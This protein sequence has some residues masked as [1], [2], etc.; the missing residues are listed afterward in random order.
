VGAE[1]GAG[2]V[3]EAA[4]AARGFRGKRLMVARDMVWSESLIE[5][6]GL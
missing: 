4:S 5:M 1:A 3:T 2:A 6:K